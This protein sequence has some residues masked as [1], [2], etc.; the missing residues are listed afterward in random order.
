M[1]IL[2]AAWVILKKEVV[3][4]LRDRKTV[5]VMVVLPLVLYPL[6]FMGLGQATK[7]QQESIGQAT[8]PMGISGGEAPQEL[9]DKLAEIESSTV[10]RV[11]DP[12]VAM[13]G[14]EVV[15]VAVLDDDF[16]QAI[17]RGGQG[18][19]TLAFDGSDE[20]SREAMERFQEAV[21]AYAESVRVKRLTA[22]NLQEELF[23]PVAMEAENVAPPARQGG[24]LLGQILPMLVSMLMIGAAFYPAID[25]TAGEKERGTLQTLL[26]APVDAMSIVA[27]KFGAVVVLSLLTGIMNLISMALVTVSIPLPEEVD[28]SLTFAVPWLNILLILACLVFL[29]M[30]FGAVMMAVA[31]T[32]RSFKDAQNY[33]TPLYLL[34]IFPLMISSLPGVELDPALAAA[35][36]INLALAMKDLLLGD[37]DSGRLFIVFLSSAVWTALGLALAARMF[38]LEAALIGD[39]GIS[40]LFHRRETGDARPLVATVPELVTFLAALLGLLFYGSIALSGQSLLVLIH[41]TQWCFILLPTLLLVRWLKLDPVRTFALRRPS[42][43]AMLLAGLFGVG[44]WYGA[45]RFMLVAMDHWM[46]LPSPEMQ[47]F[48]EAFTELGQSPGT[49]ALLFLGASVA[50]AIAEELLF[51][52]LVLQSIKRHLST[53]WAVLISSAIFAAYHLNLQQ[54]PTAFVVGVALGAL[55]IRSGSVLPGMLLHMLHNGLALVAQLY[56]DEETLMRPEMWLLLLGPAV[57]VVVLL[58]RKSHKGFREANL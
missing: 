12:A 13:A 54:L 31:V 26:T 23:T 24:W 17:D 48:G 28:A 22:A 32:A 57:A 15:A 4:T 9:L 55:A 44:L 38:R 10:T 51:R 5:I 34:C 58:K 19:V 29:G 39:A 52:G 16:I 46:P 43:A 37:I 8:L 33:L 40:A 20:L 50:P 1:T 25:L 3:E 36:V 56:L 18:S 42:T 47:A 35:P 49:A 53:R 27:G 2:D 6:L 7:A 14:G 11:E 30:M 41:V 45:Y 21:Q